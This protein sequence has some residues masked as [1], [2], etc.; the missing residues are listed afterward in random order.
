MLDESS[1]D[2]FFAF[3]EEGKDYDESYFEP[4]KI[5]GQYRQLFLKV[6]YTKLPRALLPQ[7]GQENQ[8]AQVLPAFISIITDSGNY[9]ELTKEQQSCRYIIA[10]QN[11][12]YAGIPA[13][14]SNGDYVCSSD[15]LLMYSGAATRT[16]V[17][18]I[19]LGGN[20]SPME[21]SEDGK[22]YTW[23]P[24]YRG[25]LLIPFRNPEPVFKVLETAAGNERYALFDRMEESYTSEEP[26]VPSEDSS[27]PRLYW[28]RSFPETGS[29][30]TGTDSAELTGFL[31]Q[32]QS[33]YLAA[34]VPASL[35]EDQTLT[36][37]YFVTQDTGDVSELEDRWRL[38]VPA[39]NAPSQCLPAALRSR[40]PL[41]RCPPSPAR[42]SSAAI[43]SS[44]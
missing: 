38:P 3:L 12:A 33:A 6:F 42:C 20:T 21:L 4:V 29:L 39:A 32:G 41:T 8:K 2:Q 5:D 22:S 23:T 34:T 28:S 16:E 10:G 11:R 26:P 27:G 18:D 1:G 31:P 19:P 24:D 43:P 14:K 25:N 17:L 36:A 44:S 7:A 13:S 15:G 40:P 30:R 37:K 35:Q 9:A